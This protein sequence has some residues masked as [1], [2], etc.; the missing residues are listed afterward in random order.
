M[1]T[2]LRAPALVKK[3]MKL[4]ADT[5][6]M[7]TFSPISVAAWRTRLAAVASCWIWLVVPIVIDL[8]SAPA[9]LIRA[10]ALV[11]LTVG[12]GRLFQFFWNAALP[13]PHAP[14]FSIARG[15]WP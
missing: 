4:A 7:V 12:T 10:R 2:P 1:S 5:E 9:A 3:L 15:S 6:S 11:R 8:P 14:G 13:Y